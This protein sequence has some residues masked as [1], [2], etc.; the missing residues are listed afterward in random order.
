MNI[1]IDLD[2][3]LVDFW[4]EMLVFYNKRYGTAFCKEQFF[5]YEAWRVFGGTRKECIER[6]EDFYTSP[7]FKTI[8]ALLLARETVATIS[9]QHVCVVITGRPEY[10]ASATHELI[11]MH[12][13]GIFAGVHFTNAYALGIMPRL[14]KDI[15]AALRIE[16]LLEDHWDHALPCAEAGIRVVL[17]DQPWN[18][19]VERRHQNITRVYSWNEIPCLIL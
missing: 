1:G 5:S 2:D 12:F 6:I 15:C 7:S 13:P 17:F 8:P 16:V 3:V 9:Q 4:T 10:T 18:R 19:G 11:E 14:K